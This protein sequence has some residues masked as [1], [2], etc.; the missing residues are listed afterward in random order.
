[1]GRDL[2]VTS[3]LISGPDILAIQ[4]KLAALGLAPGAI[5]GRF[6]P[7]TAGAVAAF[8]RSCGLPADGWV[9]P[10]TRAALEAAVPAPGAP[11]ANARDASL[12]GPAALGEAVK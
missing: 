7:T 10:E 11:V 8:Q 4:Q 12:L 1:M 5:D 6:G 2:H 9:G 3:P